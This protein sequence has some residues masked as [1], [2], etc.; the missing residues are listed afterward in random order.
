MPQ[1]SVSLNIK[2]TFF[3]LL[4]SIQKM[5]PCVNFIYILCYSS[6]WRRSLHHPTCL[7]STIPNI[8]RSLQ[9]IFVDLNIGALGILQKVC[10]PILSSV[11][12]TTHTYCHTYSH[13]HSHSFTR[14][15][16]H[17]L[18]VKLE[19]PCRRPTSQWFR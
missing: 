9:T 3:S 16:T 15:H 19:S 12:M 6:S 2:Q 18:R 8:N 13:T 17:R 11:S 5:S 14:I 10:I 7:Y 1:N 4:V